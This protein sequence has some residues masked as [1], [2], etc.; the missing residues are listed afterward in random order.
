VSVVAGS[1]R[2][3][4]WLTGNGTEFIVDMS[5]SRQVGVELKIAINNSL[6]Q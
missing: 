5:G 2:Q 6:V 4:E 3:T 1:L